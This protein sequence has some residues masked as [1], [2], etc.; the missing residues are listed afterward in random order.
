MDIKEFEALQE[1]EAGTWCIED[2]VKRSEKIRREVARY[3]MMAKQMG[4]KS[5]L[6]TSD[7]VIYDIGAGPAQGVSS[8]LPCKQRVCVDPN[9]EA[10][11][12]YFNVSNY[13]DKLAEDLKHDLSIPDL[14]ISTNCIDHFKDPIEFLTDLNR[15]MKYGAYFCHFHAIDNAIQH[16]H[17]AHKFNLNEE[18]INNIMRDNFELVWQMNYRNDNLVYGWLKEKSFTQ[19]FRRINNPSY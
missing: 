10:Y 5:C 13:S 17:P 4:L 16:P 12:R 15:Y 9:K 19:L 7:L 2:P 14:I 18:M 8:V 6:D 1:I 3:P 11:S